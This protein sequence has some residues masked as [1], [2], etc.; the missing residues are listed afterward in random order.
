[1]AVVY[2]TVTDGLAIRGETVNNA[3]ADI[4]QRLEQIGL[5]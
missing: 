3:R 1:M 2:A 5:R 4:P